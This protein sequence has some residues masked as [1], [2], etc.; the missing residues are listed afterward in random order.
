MKRVLRVQDFGFHRIGLSSE[1]WASW[2]AV[3]VIDKE[4]SLNLTLHH[5]SRPAKPLVRRPL[6]NRALSV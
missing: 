5:A 1:S 3:S 2:C 4:H 6:L